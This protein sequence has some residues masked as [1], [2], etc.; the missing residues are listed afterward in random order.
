MA[1]YHNRK[2]EN[3]IT[4][5]K[6]NKNKENIKE[7]N[8][9]IVKR[10]KKKKNF[11]IKK[12]IMKRIN[13]H[14]TNFFQIQNDCLND[15]YLLHIRYNFKIH[16]SIYNLL[17]ISFLNFFKVF[18]ESNQ[19]NYFLRTYEITLKIK[20]NGNFK[21][22][23]DN[24]IRLYNPTEIY[25][26]G[27][28]QSN[29]KNEYPFNGQQN[30][31]NDVKIIWYLGKTT[32]TESMFAN[33]NKIIEINLSKFDTSIVTSMDK[34]FYN[35]S[36]L[37]SLNLSN[38]NISHVSIMASMF[39]GCS[40]L[41]SLDLSNFNATSVKIIESMFSGCSSLISLNL[42]NFNA[43]KLNIMNDMFKNCFRLFSLDLSSFDTSGVTV[44]NNVFS[45]CTSLISLNLSNFVTS[46]ANYMDSMFFKCEN[47]KYINLKKSNTKSTANIN[48][49]F[50]STSDYLIVCIDNENDILTRLLDGK[51]MVYCNNNDSYHENV[52]KCHFKNSTIYNKYICNICGENF[53]INNKIQN[54]QNNNNEAYIDCFESIEGYYLD[55]DDLKYKLCYNS[56]KTCE[57]KGD[58]E[59]NN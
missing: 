15:K 55:E 13:N 50:S 52:N 16:Y 20:G 39:Y 28:S 7:E 18:L 19:K 14:E 45:G 12:C 27:V 29:I 47:L 23:S 4:L 37:I 10:K 35:C 43:T 57:I 44:M 1:Y 26:N 58:K 56:C 34:M 30:F 38:F 51:I 2:E 24:F 17:L 59:K 42:Y 8:L 36:S 53:I 41:T 54:N 11:L 46:S 33:C 5:K 6:L 40:S 21:I 9:K 32:S 25:I 48:N 3:N 31:I 49:I 22:L